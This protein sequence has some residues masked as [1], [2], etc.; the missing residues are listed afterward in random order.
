MKKTPLSGYRVV[1]GESVLG[2]RTAVKIMSE[3]STVLAEGDSF[4]D[5]QLADLSGNPKAFI[6]S[7]ARALADWL[8]K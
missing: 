7:E 4:V 3:H 1:L 5:A 6:E 8:A 2:Y